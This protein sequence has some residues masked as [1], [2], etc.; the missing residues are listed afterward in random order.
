M[1]LSWRTVRVL[2]GGIESIAVTK[3]HKGKDEA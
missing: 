2:R 3:C 1:A